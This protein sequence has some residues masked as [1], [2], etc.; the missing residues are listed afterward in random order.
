MSWT[1]QAN[2]DDVLFASGRPGHVSGSFIRHLPHFAETRSSGNAQA[3]T[4]NS[5]LKLSAGGTAGD[6]AAVETEFLSTYSQNNIPYRIWIGFQVDQADSSTDGTDDSCAI[7]AFRDIDT[8]NNGVRFDLQSLEY[9]IESDDI[10]APVASGAAGNPLN[11]EQNYLIIDCDQDADETTFRQGVAGDSVTL[12]AT[13]A[14]ISPTAAEVKSEGTGDEVWITEY[15][16]FPL[17]TI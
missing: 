2:R 3:S 10:T 14:R 11:R 5:G 7:G 12:D 17:V 4:S 6:T 9:Q 15:A 13:P 16:S 8:P 1:P